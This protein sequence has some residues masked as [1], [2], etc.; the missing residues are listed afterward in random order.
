MSTNHL[1]QGSSHRL[2]WLVQEEAHAGL[3]LQLAPLSHISHNS[4]NWFTFSLAMVAPKG[5][6]IAHTDHWNAFCGVPACCPLV[7]A[8]PD[9]IASIT[10]VTHRMSVVETLL[11]VSIMYN[12]YTE[13]TNSLAAMCAVIAFFG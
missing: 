1:K 3:L 13:P 7:S 6:G 10:I 8:Q 12:I 5:R 4:S 11:S 2:L 9:S